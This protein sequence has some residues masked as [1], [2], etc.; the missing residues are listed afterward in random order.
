M[1]I[2]QASMETRVL[3]DVVARDGIP[4]RTQVTLAVRDAALDLSRRRSLRKRAEILVDSGTATYE[5]PAD[6][7]S[8]IRL[9]SLLAEGQEV[10][11]TPQGLIPI[12]DT[13]Q[14]EVT[15]AGGQI[16]FYP[17]PGYSA[18]RYLWYRAGHVPDESDTYPDMTADEARL[19]VLKAR[20]ACLRLQ[21]NQAAQE[22]WQYAIGDEKIAKE[23]LSDK[24]AKQADTLE[25]EYLEAVS[26]GAGPL[27][28][29]P[30]R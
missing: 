6:F 4:S 23:Q 12:A 24:L 9:E 2:A 20:A 13:F 22:A 5:L 15:I 7:I 3:A 17:T 27:G 29:R 14:E 16:T 8:L 19:V 11:N 21:A 1:A 25:K 28:L 26:A 10:L 30:Y 18:T